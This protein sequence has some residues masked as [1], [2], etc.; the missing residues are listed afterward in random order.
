M[1]N[2]GRRDEKTKKDIEWL[3][4]KYLMKIWYKI[5]HENNI[6]EGTSWLQKKKRKFKIMYVSWTK[7]L[8]Y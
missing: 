3:K 5:L 7:I 6:S 2:D 8:D 1:E 4:D